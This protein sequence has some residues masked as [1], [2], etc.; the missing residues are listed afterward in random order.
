MGE[1]VGESEGTHRPSPRM[2]GAFLERT[3]SPIHGSPRG[4]SLNKY[5]QR[6]SPIW[7]PSLPISQRKQA[8]QRRIEVSPP[9]RG[10]RSEARAAKCRCGS[11]T[12]P[13]PIRFSKLVEGR[14]GGACPSS[15]FLTFLASTPPTA[16]FPR[17]K[18]LAPPATGDGG[19][20]GAGARGGAKSA[21]RV[22]SPWG[23]EAATGRA[24]PAKLWRS[25][26]LEEAAAEGEL[27]PVKGAPPRSGG[28][29]GGCGTATSL[30][31]PLCAKAE[32][33]QENSCVG[34]F[35]YN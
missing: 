6:F 33:G 16:P 9:R 26:P 13:P 15:G 30:I 8:S 27:C 14:G 3:Q 22:H 28:E 1:G 18:H 10:A 4:T 23:G 24:G 32:V 17:V 20:E 12:P 29:C 25:L 11:E 2:N 34:V 21:T 7:K 5:G 35:V 31:I 19:G